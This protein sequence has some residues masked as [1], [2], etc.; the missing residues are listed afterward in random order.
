MFNDPTLLTEP[1]SLAVKGNAVHES[2][3]GSL[4]VLGGLDGG[5]AK[6]GVPQ[7]E[8]G[9]EHP[10]QGFIFG[11]SVF[12]LLGKPRMQ[13]LIPSSTPL[14]VSWCMISGGST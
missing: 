13:I 11:M 10:V 6:A 5:L 8:V 7:L 9:V 14:Q 1:V 2:V 12:H 4:V 3:D